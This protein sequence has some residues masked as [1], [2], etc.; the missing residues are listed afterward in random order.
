MYFR[1]VLI[2]TALCLFFYIPR[3]VAADA[4]IEYVY[5]SSSLQGHVAY[6]EDDAI[7]VLGS[8]SYLHFSD[9]KERC[10]GCSKP[11]STSSG[12]PLNVEGS[13]MSVFRRPDGKIVVAGVDHGH[14]T[15]LNSLAKDTRR[16]YTTMSER[17]WGQSRVQTVHEAR[18]GSKVISAGE[19][20]TV[21]LFRDNARNLVALMDSSHFLRERVM[22]GS[23]S[24]SDIIRLANG[25][26]VVIGFEALDRLHEQAM[27]WELSPDLKPL[28]ATKIDLSLKKSSNGDAIAQVVAVGNDVYGLF[29]L[30][31]MVKDTRPDGM[32]LRQL[33]GGTSVEHKMPY[34][35]YAILRVTPDGRPFIATVRDGK[36]EL[37]FLDPATGQMKTVSYNR[38]VSPKVC[39]LEGVRMEVIDVLFDAEGY[40]N[41]ILNS[42][43]LD[44]R[45]AGCVTVGKVRL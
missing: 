44:H 17:L 35:Y 19:N 3:A 12:G 41:V 2:F 11:Y 13:P 4:T 6:L 5:V 33:M 37:R 31:D 18:I 42:K 22:F 24:T 30:R 38:P 45:E 10:R 1:I 23:G 26:Y 16:G 32:V 8:R 14:V 15:F 43:P 7:V 21:V 39:F 9:P 27:L 20:K 36:P 29:G 34:D 28:A 25:N 40:A